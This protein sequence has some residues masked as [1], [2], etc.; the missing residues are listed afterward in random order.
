V[1]ARRA[2]AR[3]GV[4]EQLWRQVRWLLTGPV[5]LL[6]VV[7]AVAWYVS[8][9]ID[10][11]RRPAGS[12]QPSIT[13][14]DHE[15]SQFARLGNRYG[16][17]L[18]LEQISPWVPK[19]V[20]AAEDRRFYSHPGI[21]P[22]GIA[23]A[24]VRNLQ[25][26]QIVQ[27]GSTI[28]QQLAKLAFLT[29]ER[30]ISRKVKEALYTLWLEAR[31]DKK[32]ILEAYLNRVY[33]GAGAYGIDAAA[34]RYFDKPASGLSLPEAAMLAGLIR[35]PSR[36]APIRDLELARTRAAA[37]LDGMREA[38]QITSAEA[39]SAKAGPAALARPEI[40]ADS[41]YFADWVVAETRLYARPEQQRLEV[42]T[43]LDRNLQN[44]AEL[45]LQGALEQWGK[46]LGAGQAALVAMTRQG[47]V[48]AMMGG[49]S[50]A[51]TQFN[52]ATQAERQPGSAFKLFVYLAALEAGFVPSDTVSGA[53]V[54]VAGWR[55]ANFND[56]Y[57][58]SLSLTDSFAASVN[59]AAVRLSEE[60]GRDDVIAMAERLGI[61]SGLRSHPSIALGTS[62]VSLLELTAAYATVANGGRLVWP[63]GIAA[64]SGDDGQMLYESRTV[65][66]PV[67]EPA[68]VRA[69]T[70]M[71]ET[72]MSRGT[73]QQ[74]SLRRFV[75]GKTGTS[76]DHRDA[77][78]VGFTEDIVVGVWVGNDDGAPMRRV[79]G[80]GLPARIFRDFIVRA[81]GERPFL[82]EPAPNKPSSGE[83]P[84]AAVKEVIGDA[85]EGLLDSLGGLVGD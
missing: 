9:D 21:D 55:P 13:L 82:P 33:F 11:L 80:G 16:E 10:D 79:T 59:T 1:S 29:P 50:Y 52:R 39:A 24:L 77:W 57:P 4:A 85:F 48:R 58:Q 41:G 14:L 40:R 17:Y 74:G 43:T 32:E 62:E 56:S 28:S 67:L 26:G 49:R 73:G 64:V 2:S 60:V 47:E 20:I 63:Q 27:G 69:M 19:A 44:A 8:L 12:S 81:Y 45:A 46:E 53:P 54:E 61:T 15:G 66:E 84:I 70:A 22:I 5:G 36:Y 38:G 30:S 23:R 42:G 34:S 7:V 78:F 68:V 35:A 25:A 51:D 65:D 37:V 75:A 83:Y 71:L 31:F 6:L 18:E 76:A 3:P 72:T